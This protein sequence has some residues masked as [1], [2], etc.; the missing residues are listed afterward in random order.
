VVAIEAISDGDTDSSRSEIEDIFKQISHIQS[1]LEGTKIDSTQE[2][3]LINSLYEAQ[4]GKNTLEL[5]NKIISLS[6]SK[7]MKPEC[8][9]SFGLVQEVSL[10]F[11]LNLEN[12][13]TI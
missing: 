11:M 3:E 7:A 10:F 13:K 2:V 6:R 4:D 1:R 9:N 12:K 5:Y 8:L